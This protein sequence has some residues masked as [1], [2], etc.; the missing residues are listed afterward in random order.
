ML[1]PQREVRSALVWMLENL[2]LLIPLPGVSG[3]QW[4]FPLKND[5]GADSDND[6]GSDTDSDTGTTIDTETNT[7]TDIGTDTETNLH[8]ACEEA[9]AGFAFG[10]EGDPCEAPDW[11][12]E[13]PW[14]AGSDDSPVPHTGDCELGTAMHGDYTNDLIAHAI[15]PSIDLTPCEG[16]TVKLAWH[17]WRKLHPNDYVYLDFYSHG[18]WNEGVR[19]WTEMQW[20]WVS[21]KINVT[22][23]IAQD[24]QLRFRIVTNGNLVQRGVYIDDLAMVRE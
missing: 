19:S 10:F 14:E 3:C 9:L 16:E 6:T 20:V 5:A 13:S 12:L 1:S 8:A 22:S 2:L 23:F 24:F 15:S 11:T 18:E 17:Q 21:E 4:E 7:W